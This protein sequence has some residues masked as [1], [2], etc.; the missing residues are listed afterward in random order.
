MRT[1][2]E[3]YKKRIIEMVSSIEDEKILRRIFLIII[4]IIRANNYH[5]KS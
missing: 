3:T 2:K 4:T 1:E 5:Y